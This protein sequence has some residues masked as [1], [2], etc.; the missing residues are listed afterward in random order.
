MSSS[1]TSRDILRY[2]HRRWPS[3]AQHK[4][5]SFV[6]QFHSP[7]RTS[8]I[9]STMMHV[10]AHCGFTSRTQV[11]SF[12]CKGSEW[13]TR[14]LAVHETRDDMSIQ[15]KNQG[16]GVNRLDVTRGRLTQESSTARFIDQIH[17]FVVI[18]WRVIF[19]K[20]QTKRYYRTKVVRILAYT[21]TTV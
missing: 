10:A 19:T 5:P 14:D 20:T 16:T 6:H 15:C 1:R 17:A 7:L 13:S 12:L 8:S 21:P 11:R 3:T 2:I 4:Q 9:S 18:I